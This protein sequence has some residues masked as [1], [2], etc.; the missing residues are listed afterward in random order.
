MLSKRKK[1]FLTFG[2]LMMVAAPAAIV[3]SCGVEEVTSEEI[4]IRN[5]LKSTTSMDKVEEIW[6]NKVLTSEMNSYDKDNPL[7]NKTFSDMFNLY[8]ARKIFESNTYL[9]TINEKLLDMKKFQE[10]AKKEGKKDP[11]ELL[12]YWGLNRPIF[13]G[14]DTQNNNYDTIKKLLETQIKPEAKK[15]I[16]ENFKDIQRDVYKS[17][18]SMKYLFNEKQTVN[19]D[20][21]KHVFYGENNANTMSENEKLI[22]PNKD[23]NFA[24]IAEAIK[25]HLFIKWE[26][27]VPEN[28]MAGKYN[29]D[30]GDAAG[31]RTA[32]EMDKLLEKNA[33][34]YNDTTYTTKY[35]IAEDQ[36]NELIADSGQKTYIGYKGISSFQG[37]EGVLSLGTEDIKLA[38]TKDDWTG[39]VVDGKFEKD[40]IPFI[41]K[42][43]K[44]VKVTRVL[45]LMP[46]F[47]NNYLSF[48]SAVWTNERLERLA[49]NLSLSN[50]VYSS[51]V[52]YFINREKDPIKLKIEVDL[53][54]K[55]AIEHGFKFIEE[56]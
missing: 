25:Q 21:Y 14:V 1:A 3:I 56:K 52:E 24:L 48:D 7:A 18:M 26:V 35:T 44:T 28:K 13:I 47:S 8:V 23:V 53:L 40:K 6:W 5:Q 10:L 32:A 33:D 42:G 12:T 39:Y 20:E 9:R 37:K 55:N 30:E 54:R 15:F 2:S 43:S 17:V 22:N 34:L 31:I 41:P 49:L 19:K 11:T 38:T 51:A 27:S 16:F 46:T 29:Y 45:G 36:L 50:S 4:E